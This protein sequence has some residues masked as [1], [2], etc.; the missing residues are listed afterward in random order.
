M[1]DGVSTVVGM[2]PVVGVSSTIVAPASQQTGSVAPADTTQAN[3][4]M[5][6]SLIASLLSAGMLILVAKGKD[7]NVKSG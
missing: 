3:P 2:S 4:A 5:M 7:G 6:T 1:F